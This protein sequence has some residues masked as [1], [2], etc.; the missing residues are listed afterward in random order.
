MRLNRRSPLISLALPN[1]SSPHS[2]FTRVPCFPPLNNQFH[3]T[4]YSDLNFVRFSTITTHLVH[5]KL[6]HTR[7]T[8]AFCVCLHRVQSSTRNYH[9]LGPPGNTTHQVHQC[10]SCVFASCPIL[11][12]KSPRTWSTRKYH[13]PGPPVLFV[14]V[15]I[16]SNYP[17]ENT[18][19]LVHQCLSCVCIQ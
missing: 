3:S 14:C 17:P 8:S 7:S 4:A 12:Q 1:N 6:P 15:C 10:F 2:N 16:V 13:T 19:H 5:K 18:T 11:H 9:A